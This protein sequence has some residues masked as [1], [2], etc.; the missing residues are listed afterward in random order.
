MATLAS[1]ILRLAVDSSLYTA[2]LRSSAAGAQQFAVNVQASMNQAG[3]AAQAAGG[4]IAAAQAILHG[5][6]RGAGGR[7][8]SPGIVVAQNAQAGA[9]AANTMTVAVQGTTQ[10][11]NGL[12]TSL[13]LG[14]TIIA[15]FLILGFVAFMV[16]AAKS[17]RD[18][19]S[20][21]LLLRTQ[22][23]ATLTEVDNMSKAV[24]NMAVGVRT[25]PVELARGLYHIESV[26]IRGARALEILTRAAQGARVGNADLEDVTN[27]LIAS[28]TTGIKGVNNMAEAMGTLDG[29]VGSGNMRMEDLAKSFSSGVLATAKAFGLSIQDVG[30]ALASMTDQGIP[31]QEAATRLRITIALIGAPTRAAAEQLSRIG[32]SSRALADEMRG[33]EGLIGA[34]RLLSAHL[35]KSG[36]DATE[37]AQ[38]LK[39]AF[40]GSRSSAGLL[41][42][43]ASLDLLDLKM[44]TIKA[45]SKD[46]GR[47]AAMQAETAAGKF[48]KFE[49]IVSVLAIDVGNALL[50]VLTVMASIIGEV[51]KQ[52]EILVPLI[53]ALSAIITILVTKALYG[54]IAQSVLATQKIIIQAAA[55]PWLPRQLL[56]HMPLVVFQRPWG[57]CSLSL[58]FRSRPLWPSD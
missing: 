12:N 32:L 36:M 38:L 46:F 22:A 49:A 24:M 28:V 13:A 25:G 14:K 10:A 41:T 27:A 40:G 30:A 15:S 31:A 6:A 20:E 21:M 54:F 17:A 2:G 7:F 48:Q 51:A 33:P 4:Q 1:L 8:A 11:V 37:Q 50:P 16:G 45:A 34:L 44:A 47:V 52:T 35:N 55:T 42:L 29:I 19:Q 3:A 43:M 39:A 23:R 56:Q 53:M 5:A 18:F 57:F 58:L 26:G 9:A